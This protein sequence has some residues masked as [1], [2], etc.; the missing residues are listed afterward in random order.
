MKKTLFGLLLLLALSAANGCAM[1][2]TPYDDDYAA[3]GGRWQRTDMRHGRVGSAFDPGATMT[4]AGQ[5]T[6]AMP[7]VET[8]I[9]PGH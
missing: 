6:P 1:C 8:Y 3:F 2:C 9:Q 4:T 7:P 5:P